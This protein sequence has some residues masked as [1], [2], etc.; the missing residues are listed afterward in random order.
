M[1]PAFLICYG[2]KCKW[3]GNNSQCE[4]KKR[5]K[6]EVCCTSFWD[7]VKL[8]IRS[9]KTKLLK[10]NVSI[11]MKTWRGYLSRWIAKVNDEPLIE[12]HSDEFWEWHRSNV[13]KKN[14][15]SR[16]SI[17]LSS[18]GIECYPNDAMVFITEISRWLTWYRHMVFIYD[19]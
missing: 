10:L 2:N 5:C 19:E 8:G 14:S 11:M 9:L 6:A 7:E 1:M 17:W 18:N 15:K 12:S 13:I 4:I 16:K 3:S